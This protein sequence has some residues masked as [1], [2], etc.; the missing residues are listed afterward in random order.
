MTGLVAC[1]TSAPIGKVA[2]SP[3]FAFNI[4]ITSN[5]H[6]CEPTPS[7]LC[8]FDSYTEIHSSQLHPNEQ[9][10]Q[11]DTQ[12]HRPTK[13][14]NNQHFVLKQPCG[15]PESAQGSHRWAVHRI[16]VRHRRDAVLDDLAQCHAPS[17]G[18]AMSQNNC[19]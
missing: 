7:N 18:E 15:R 13:T 16:G 8:N 2:H 10:F 1:H 14:T 3:L 19:I 17:E 9:Q 5:V 6:R 12:V 11:T 4:R